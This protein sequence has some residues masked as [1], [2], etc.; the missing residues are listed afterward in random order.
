MTGQLEQTPKGWL[1]PKSLTG[2]VAADLESQRIQMT[3]KFL[4][5]WSSD[6]PRVGTQIIFVDMNG[7]KEKKKKRM[8]REMK[9]LSVV[10]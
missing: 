6:W 4:Y 8:A 5:G 10:Q 2:C 7:I 3:P 1:S 9:K